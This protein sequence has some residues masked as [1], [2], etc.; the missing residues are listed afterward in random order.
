MI[1]AIRHR[2]WKRTQALAV[3]RQHSANALPTNREDAPAVLPVSGLVSPSASL[4]TVAPPFI[5]SSTFFSNRLS[6]FLSLRHHP[7]ACHGGSSIQPLE[8]II[9]KCSVFSRAPKWSLL[10]ILK[11]GL[12]SFGED[13]PVLSLVETC[14]SFYFKV[15]S[16]REGSPVIPALCASVITG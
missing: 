15:T 4:G 8:R 3:W 9:V 10:K 5:I 2:R 6:W 16:D 13:N 1:C 14:S 7:C 12:F 11:S